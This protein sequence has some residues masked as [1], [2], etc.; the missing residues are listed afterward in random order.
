[1]PEKKKYTIVLT[2]E[3]EATD[4]EDAIQELSVHGLDT[5]GIIDTFADRNEIHAKAKFINSI[6]HGRR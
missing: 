5:D 4:E 2:L 3:L 1:M 6:S